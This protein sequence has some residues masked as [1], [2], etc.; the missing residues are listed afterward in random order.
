MN[1]VALIVI[2]E[3]DTIS[4]I[5]KKGRKKGSAPRVDAPS[6]LFIPPLSFQGLNKSV[7]SEVR[8]KTTKVAQTS[9]SPHFEI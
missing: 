1:S 8:A 4:M 2:P 6:F 7:Q 5:N 3:K 9:Q